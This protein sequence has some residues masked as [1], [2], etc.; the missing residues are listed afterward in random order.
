MRQGR[1]QGGRALAGHDR[2]LGGQ[3]PAEVADQVGFG[4]RGLGSLDRGDRFLDEALRLRL[5]ERDG[6]Y[7]GAA[8]G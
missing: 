6:R 5:G 7:L 1:E 3:A 4:P 8:R 2:D